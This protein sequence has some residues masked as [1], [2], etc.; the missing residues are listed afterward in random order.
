MMQHIYGILDSNGCHVDVSSSERGAKNYATRNGY[1][2]VTIRYG[3]GYNAAIIARK[4]GDKWEA[5]E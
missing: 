3:C 1:N 2:A 4:V 5:V